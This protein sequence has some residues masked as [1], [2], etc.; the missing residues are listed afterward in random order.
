MVQEPVQRCRCQ[1]GIATEGLFT[2][3]KAQIRRQDDRARFIP[4]GYDLEEQVR[5]GLAERE[6][7]YLVDSQQSWAK[8]AP[9]EAILVAPLTLCALQMKHQIRRRHEA[10]LDAA[11][12]GQIA[13]SDG[14]VR[15][16]CPAGPEKSFSRTLSRNMGCQRWVGK[17]AVG[18]ALFLQLV[19]LQAGAG[20]AWTGKVVGI[21][22]G[23][24]ITVLHDGHDQVKIRLYGID[25]TRVRP[26]VRQGLEAEPVI[27]CARA[28][29]AGRSHGY[30]QVRTHRGAD[31]R[32]RG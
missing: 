2:L 25:S 22:D 31:L 21:A 29:G 28:I 11:L 14:Q 3:P 27:H 16:S 30:G 24:T 20:C 8:D 13:Q 5:L 1:R 26:A 7:A 32:G 10:D 19:L 4:L 15:L 6:I 12:R 18:A 23:D 9:L 17:I